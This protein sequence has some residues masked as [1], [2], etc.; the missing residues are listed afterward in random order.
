MLTHYLRVKYNLAPVFYL[1]TWPFGY[2]ICSISDPDVAYQV[3]VQISLPKHRAT[4]ERLWPL[5][6]MKNLATMDGAEHKRWRAI[7]NPGF[8]NAHLMSLVEGIVDDAVL[9]TEIL[10]KHAETKDVF[11]L[12][13]A[14]T[15]VTVDIIGRVIL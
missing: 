9:F 13:N 15:N 6:G 2:A 5:I 14:A 12:E 4:T 3:T 11:S 8:S 7:F 1:D 10:A